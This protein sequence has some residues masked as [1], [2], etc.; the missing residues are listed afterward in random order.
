MRDVYSQDI[1]DNPVTD[2]Y[3]MAHEVQA[4]AI[5]FGAKGRNAATA[6]FI[7]SIAERVIQI[8]SEFPLMVVRPKGKTSGLLDILMEI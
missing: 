6:F 7:G 1:N 8:D 3:D 4:D 5:I 2:I